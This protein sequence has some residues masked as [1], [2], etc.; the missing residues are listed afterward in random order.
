MYAFLDH[1]DA[2]AI[3]ERLYIRQADLP[4]G[5]TRVPLKEVHTN[6]CPALV[7]WEHLREA[8]FAR[9]GI[10]PDAVQRRAARVR[11]AG[12]A[13]AE[14]VRRVFA[15]ER[16][17][18][19]VDVDAA[20]YDGFIGDGDK[21]LLAQVR[22]TPP[23]LLA[24]AQYAFRD[25][26]LPEL[27][28]RYRAR[29]WPDSLLPAE[30]ERWNAYRRERLDIDSGLSECTFARLRDEIAQL[31]PVHAGAGDK[32]VLLD[33]LLAWADRIDAGLR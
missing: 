12:P 9:L 23:H 1:L 31:R 20:L 8:D 2:D 13:I 7:A 26:R 24:K 3:A 33:R 30:R 10:D 19:S 15:R 14:K 16:P 22:G 11:A 4:D 29:N 27:L 5:E 6:K 18:D 25:E 32:Q 17:A 21:R 28:F